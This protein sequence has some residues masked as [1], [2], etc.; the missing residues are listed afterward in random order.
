MATLWSGSHGPA[1]AAAAP[2]MAD[3]Q[4][5]KQWAP[6]GTVLTAC[7][8]SIN[9]LVILLIIFFFWRFFSGKPDPSSAGA[10][11]DDDD[12]PLPVASPWATRRYR[13]REAPPKQP[14]DVAKALPVY[15]YS[16]AGEGGK[17]A[18]CAVC[19]VELK[20]GDSARRL[21]RCGHRFHADCVGTWLRL[22]ATCPLCRAG[23]AE[24]MNAKD[25]AAGGADC[26]V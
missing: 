18:E 22:H 21:P 12:D 5:A 17:P 14:L 7:V 8:V 19:I 2:A 9:I 6:H 10:E 15:V 23:V 26:P 11:D 24:P 25:A 16:S 4:A 1:A 20:D 13:R 3:E